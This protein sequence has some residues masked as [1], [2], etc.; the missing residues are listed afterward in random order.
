MATPV[1]HLQTDRPSGRQFRCLAAFLDPAEIDALLSQLPICLV[2]DRPLGAVMAEAHQLATGLP[3]YTSAPVIPLPAAMQAAATEVRS[4]EVFRREYE[5]KAVVR[6]GMVPLGSLIA[7]QPLADMDYV[8]ELDVQVPATAGGEA[9]VAFAFPVGEVPEPAVVGKS[10]VFTTPGP[11]VFANPIPTYRAV[12]GG[13]EVIARVE[14]RPNYLYVAEFSS[15]TGARLV[16]RNGVHHVLAL[17]RAGRTHAPAV[18]S[19]ASTIDELGLPPTS[20]LRRVGAPRPPLVRDFLEP[21]AVPL[22]KRATAIA[23][24]VTLEVGQLVFPADGLI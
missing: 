6:L 1:E 22:V 15:P 7:P 14:A 21:A 24:P 5:A 8:A 9:D 18:V 13:Y 2:D 4:R 20:L 11:S 16:L 12:P 19:Q 3:P 17:L 23:T 10:V